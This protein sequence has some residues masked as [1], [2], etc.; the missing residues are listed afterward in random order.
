MIK[1]I[2]TPTAFGLL[3]W[4]LLEPFLLVVAAFTLVHLLAD[5]ADRF[6]DLTVNRAPMAGVEY[7]VLRV[8]YIVTK[9]LPVSLL[10]GVMFGFAMLNRSREIV[11]MQA[12]GISRLQIAMPL[13]LIAVVATGFDFVVSE[14]VVPL[15]N[16]CA[17]EVLAA[18]IRKKE[19][20]SSSMG[21]TWIRT[22]DAFVVAEDYDSSR[23]QMSDVTIFRFD[24]SEQLR[25]ITQVSSA[26]W[27]GQ[28]WHFEK[29]R[30]FGVGESDTASVDDDTRLDLSPD[31]LET[32]ITVNPDDF[33][34]A[35]LSGFIHA[36]QRVGL[37]PQRYLAN[38]DLKYAMPVS[39]LI[40]AAIGFALSLDPLP[41]HGGF[42]RSIGYALA[43][44]FG[45]WLV[46][47]FTMSFGKSGVLPPW[48]A[49]WLPNLV[50]GSIAVSM[51]L[52]GE[53]K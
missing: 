30:S 37:N 5:A 12:L 51:F 23:K 18:R 48:P 38:R 4:G 21:E 25:A 49:A 45:Y 6:N 52:M 39:C 42:A 16:R 1:R 40:L 2:A 34:L 9:L 43:A 22:R 26:R 41:R 31:D 7:L 27:F 8:P 46:L 3:F 13:V 32:P 20:V 44:G 14:T 15:T 53:E 11:A 33:S 28:R 36:L 35:E 24:K 17:E 50:F 29:I 10:A 19:H 47:G